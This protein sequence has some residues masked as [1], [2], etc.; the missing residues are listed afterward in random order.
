MSVVYN[1]RYIPGLLFS[2]SREFLGDF[3][4]VSTVSVWKC[5]IMCYFN[6]T[7]IET[8]QVKYSYGFT[9]CVCTSTLIK[10]DIRHL[11]N[12]KTF[13]FQ[14]NAVLL[15]FLFISESRSQKYEAAKLFST[16]IIIRNVSWAAYQNDFCRIMWHWRLEEWCWKFSFDH[17]NKWHFNI[18]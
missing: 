11:Y 16:L 10:S 2:V 12:C 3:F 13:L 4:R 7:N 17:K 1:L 14:I 6:C 18:Y 5:L 9:F 15:K 8:H